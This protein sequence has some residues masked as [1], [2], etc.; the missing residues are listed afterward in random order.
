MPSYEK[1]TGG[2]ERMVPPMIELS[3]G[4]LYKKM[5]GWG[6]AG[7]ILLDGVSPP[8]DQN[9]KLLKVECSKWKH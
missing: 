3:V 4:D 9:I 8:N 2:G 5:P 1:I 7:V 6:L